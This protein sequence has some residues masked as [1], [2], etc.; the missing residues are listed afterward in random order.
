MSELNLTHSNGNKVK[1]TT[2]DTLSANKTFKLPGADGSVGQVLQTDGSGALSFTSQAPSNRRL[3]YN[4][5]MLVN[6]RGNINTG[7][8]SYY[9]G[10]DRYYSQGNGN[11]NGNWDI[12]QSTDVPDGYGFKYSLSYDC[13]TTS[14]HA[15]RYLM[16]VYRMEGNDSMVFNYGTANAKTVT[17]S[18]WIKCS[19]AGNFQVNFENEDGVDAGYQ[20]QQT[21][22][23]AG[24]WEKKVVT[25]PGDTSKALIFGT[26]KAFCFDIMYSA[27]GTYA[28]GT[29]SAA[30]STLSNTQRGGHCN[31][32]LFDSTS[33]Y[34]RITGVQLELGD[35]A[36]DFEHLPYQVELQRCKR[37]YQTAA[38][39]TMMGSLAGQVGTPKILFE[40]E[41]RAIP[42]SVTTEY[43]GNGNGT[44]RNQNDGST[45]TG[46]TI[47]NYYINGFDCRGNNGSA[48]IIY[49][50]TYKADAE[51]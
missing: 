32:D 23:T 49:S 19:K 43:S 1:L 12:G 7:S 17:L 10:P 8:F 21:I 24:Q 4:G 44:F 22:N 33:N 30:W 6:Q 48:N 18:F 46:N 27:F 38:Y 5:A 14:S 2:P 13:T 25:I 11:N 45:L 37:Y 40:V 9:Y 39:T 34:V 51:I 16:T 50:S 15:D 28:S 36:T 29:P 20:T 41:M 47:F 31:I 26:Q 35:H 42:S 3:N